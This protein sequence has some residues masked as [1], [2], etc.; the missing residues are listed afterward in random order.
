MI[1]ANKAARDLNRELIGKLRN[2]KVLVKITLIAE[3]SG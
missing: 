3:V 2:P 1:K